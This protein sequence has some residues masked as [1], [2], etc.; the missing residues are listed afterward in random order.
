MIFR[1]YPHFRKPIMD[2]QVI[3]SGCE[4]LASNSSFSRRMAS[5]SSL[6]LHSFEG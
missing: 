4:S 5:E 3:F 6:V 2:Q 1:G